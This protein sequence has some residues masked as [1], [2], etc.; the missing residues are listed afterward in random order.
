MLLT[1]EHLGAAQ[2]DASSLEAL[3]KLELSSLEAIDFLKLQR[4]FGDEQ[5]RLLFQI[6]SVIPYNRN[7]SQLSPEDLALITDVSVLIGPTN[8]GMLI[9]TCHSKLNA[10]ISAVQPTEKK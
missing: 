3:H 8:L 7:S 9:Y 6:F 1:M 5:V 4:R 10:L 2:A